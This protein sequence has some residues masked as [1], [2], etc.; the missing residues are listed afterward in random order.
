VKTAPPNKSAPLDLPELAD[1]G[2]RGLPRYSRKPLPPYR[3]VR[4]VHPHPTRDPRGHSY[5]EATSHERH[6]PWHP[7][8]W[9][10][11]SDWLYGVDLFHRFYFWEAHEAWEG[12]WTVMP[13][14]SAPALLLQGLIQIAAA[15]L[16]LHGGQLHGMRILSESGLHKLQQVAAIHPLLLGLD[17]PETMQEFASY[18]ARLRS[19]P[20]PRLTPEVPILRLHGALPA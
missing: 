10:T 12:L 16:K 15:L 9:R 17:I 14:E 20:S 3:Y 6:L 19:S 8:E 2:E 5:I 1:P 4:G 7:D 13:R 18:F 11:V